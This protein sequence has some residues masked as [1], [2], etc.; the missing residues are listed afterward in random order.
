MDLQEVGWGGTDWIYL[1][2][3]MNSECSNKSSGSL[4]WEFRD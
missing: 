4:K 2:H 3:N 1:A